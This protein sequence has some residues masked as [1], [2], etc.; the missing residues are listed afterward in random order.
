[1]IPEVVFVAKGTHICPC[2]V[3]DLS[4]LRST[5]MVLWNAYLYQGIQ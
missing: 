4:K 1:M 5:L 3:R 2:D